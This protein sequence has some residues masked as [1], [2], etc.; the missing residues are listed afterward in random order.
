MVKSWSK[1]ALSIL[2]GQS[3]GLFGTFFTI[4]SIPVWYVSL[5]K[6]VFSPPNWVFGPVW[7]ILYTLI[8]ISFY[9]IWIKN[10]K[11]SL[12]LFFF[13]LFLNAIWSPIFF[14]LNNMWLGLIILLT[15]VVTLVVIV[16]NFYKIDK[17]A[18][19][20]L[21]PYLLWISFASLLNYS[22]WRLNPENGINNVFAQ[23]FD[24]NKSR[25]DYVFSEDNYKSSFAL[26]DLKKNAYQKNPT[27]S[28]KEEVRISFFDFLVKRNDYKKAYLT[29]LR[30][31]TLESSGLTEDEK[32]SVYSKIDPEVVH[33]EN[34]KKE[35]QPATTLEDL[36]SKSKKEDEK[37]KNQTLPIIYFAL[38]NIGLGN[39]ITLK[40]ENIEIYRSLRSEAESLVKLG[41]VDSKLLERWFID[42][43]SE[44]GK[45]TDIENGV[46]KESPT[47]FSDEIYK[48]NKSYDS[49]LEKLSSAKAELLQLNKF[50]RELEN[51]ISEKR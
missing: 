43:D 47:V 32:E 45:I 39:V 1:L 15:M 36:L 6:P 25:E 2:L 21:A 30:V 26:F 11:G 20:L 24:F 28:L 23:E 48:I 41:R 10:K 27:L 9:K 46:K 49:V 29:M 40:N 4:S 37:Y 16:K 38:E 7:T 3:I 5:N 44:I 17:M 34:I 50:V 8:G 33:Y 31:K 13:H 12:N 18:A 51:T 14:G 35:Y 19:Y 42:I 22:I